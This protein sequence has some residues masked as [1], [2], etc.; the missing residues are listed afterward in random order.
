MGTAGHER[1]V[2][3]HE[4]IGRVAEAPD[5]SGLTKG[6]FVVGIVRSRTP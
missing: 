3:G 6:D 5:G 1:L 4:S 2:L